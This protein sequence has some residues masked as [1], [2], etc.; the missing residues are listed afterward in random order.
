MIGV[1]STLAQFRRAFTIG[2]EGISLAT[3][4]MFVMVGSY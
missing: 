1:A 4:V 3:W 2:I